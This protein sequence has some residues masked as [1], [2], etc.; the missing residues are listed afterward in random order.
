MLD[1]LLGNSS[2]LWE[3]MKLNY[4]KVLESHQLQAGIRGHWILKRKEPRCPV[5]HVNTAPLL[6]AHSSFQ[7]QEQLELEG[8]TAV[9]LACQGMDC[10]AGKAAGN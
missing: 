7:D 3:N 6:G 9:F 10:E 1:S 4:L 5:V 8:N 2:K